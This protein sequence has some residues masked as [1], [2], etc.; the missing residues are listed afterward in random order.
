MSERG[1]LGIVTEGAGLERELAGDDGET[2]TDGT[3][4]GLE[5]GFCVCED[6]T[7]DCSTSDVVKGHGGCCLT[8]IGDGCQTSDDGWLPCKER[9]SIVM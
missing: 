7:I 6:K 1:G 4:G 3:K 9:Q 2:T 8:T 5:K